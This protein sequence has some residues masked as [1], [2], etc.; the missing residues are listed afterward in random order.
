[1]VHL[2]RVQTKTCL[3]EGGENETSFKDW[4]EEDP[5]PSY[6][7]HVTGHT[8]V[9]PKMIQRVCRRPNLMNGRDISLPIY[10]SFG[11]ESAVRVPKPWG[12]ERIEK[13]N[14]EVGRAEIS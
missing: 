4:N 2:G 11:Q 12:S 13:E 6:Q 14:H 8:L 3:E 5:F 10:P 9:C 7:D 1:M